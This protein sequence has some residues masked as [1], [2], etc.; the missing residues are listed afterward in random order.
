MTALWHIVVVL[1]ACVVIAKGADW[2]VEAAARIAKRF[3]V[4]E[5]VVGLTVVAFGTSAPEFAVS[6]MSAVDGK[7]VIAFGNVVGSNVFNL[8]FILGGCAAVRAI[9]TKP[10]LVYRDGG[11]LFLT[12]CFLLLA[13]WDRRLAPWEGGL[14]LATLVGYL[15]YLAWK[16][17]PP[18]DEVPEGDPTW[19]DF[20]LLG[21][22]LILVVGASHFLVDSSVE[23]AR[24]AG[25]SDRII[26][27]TLIAAGTSLP[28]FATSMA[29]VVKGRYGIG[30]GN[31]IGSDLFNMLGVLGLAGTLELFTGHPLVIGP[32][33][34]QTTAVLAGMVLLVVIF[35]RT[36]WAVRRW[37][38]AALVLLNLGRWTYDIVAHAGDGVAGIP[39]H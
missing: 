9:Q 19:M 10:T 12:T 33:G 38:G 32:D 14:M 1:L 4:S 22:G 20:P 11:L 36:G 24:M 37:E 21:I 28:E 39:P 3:G 26:A 30:A 25:L 23:L 7:P 29:A 15:G 5:L 13:M 17:E 8:G 35:M 18:E 2:L 6:I 27:E 31:L 16:R 34:Y